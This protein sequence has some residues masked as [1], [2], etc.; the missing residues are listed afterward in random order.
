[1]VSSGQS[2]CL[3]DKRGAARYLKTSVS[4]V[5]RFVRRGELRCF[6]V[7]MQ[8]RF[9]PEDLVRFLESH[10]VRPVQIRKPKAPVSFNAST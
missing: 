4:T 7:G 8:W 3:T 5:E 1:M 6:R 2:C 10:P 9:R